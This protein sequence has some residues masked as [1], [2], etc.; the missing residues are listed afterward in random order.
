ML[1]GDFIQYRIT[2]TN[3]GGAPASAVHIDDVLPATLTYHSMSAD[4]AGWTF[5]GT[6][7]TRAADLTG[8]LV[9]GNSRFFWIRAQVK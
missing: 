6:G 2:V 8:T 4:A 5:S 9:V 3:S 7:N 1:P